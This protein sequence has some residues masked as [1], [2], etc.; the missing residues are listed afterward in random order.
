MNNVI[1]KLKEQVQ[2]M[3]SLGIPVPLFRDSLTGK[4]SITFTFF[5][6]SSVIAILG[7]L[8]RVA[9]LVSSVDSDAA[10][11]LVIVFGCFYLGRAITRGNTT[12][13]PTKEEK[14]ETNVN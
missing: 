12:S 10:K 6:F 1:E 4:P 2:K 9:K 13:E 5:Y 7:V 11:E 8:G 14:N 3:N